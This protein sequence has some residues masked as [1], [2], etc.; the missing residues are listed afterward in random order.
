VSAH[1]VNPGFVYSDIWRHEKSE[2]LL[3]VYKKWC[4]TTAQGAEGIIR[5]ATEDGYGDWSGGFLVDAR[6]SGSS[7]LAQEEE[8]C[9]WLWGVSEGLAGIVTFGSPAGQPVVTL[10]SPAGDAAIDEEDEDLDFDDSEVSESLLDDWAKS[11][12]Q[13][14]K[15][16]VATPAVDRDALKRESE[17][18]QGMSDVSTSYTEKLRDIRERAGKSM[19]QR[20][21]E[22]EKNKAPAGK[23]GVGAG[24]S[25]A[26]ARRKVVE[27]RV[28]RQQRWQTET[29]TR[30]R[31]AKAGSKETSAA[32]APAAAAGDVNLAKKNT[33]SANK[34]QWGI[35]EPAKPAASSPA[36]AP[37]ATRIGSTQGVERLA[38]RL[39]EEAELVDLSSRR[40]T[41]TM[42]RNTQRLAEY[43]ANQEAAAREAA[44]RRKVVEERVE[45]QQRWQ[46]EN[47]RRMREAKKK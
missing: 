30:M 28:E 13:K 11:A 16:A 27:E 21:L 5:A 12:M 22:L 9:D 33:L 15:P 25:E 10:D 31:E 45:R 26:A 20:L 36:A 47:A 46:E 42:K 24:D 32:P 14:E 4:K 17:A 23:N 38:K 40:N 35:T 34:A 19:T 7:A 6:P 3:K 43:R 37:A 41:V 2:R 8:P 18:V 39:K 44:A 1:A 29:A